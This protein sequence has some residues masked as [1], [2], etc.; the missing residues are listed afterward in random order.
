MANLWNHPSIIA[1]EALRHLEDALVITK[2]CAVDKTS[3]FTTRA[4]GW[5]VGDV[6]SFKTYGD[7]EVKDFTSSISAQDIRSSTRPMQITEHYDISVKVT[8]REEALDLDSFSEEVLRPAAYRMAEKLDVFVGGK[9]MDGAGLY[10][11]ANM[12]DATN[13]GAAT[14]ALARKYAILQQLTL[15]RFCIVDPTVE[16]ALLGQAWFNQSQTR[17]AAG[18]N[19]LQS[20]IMGRVM[21]MDFMA[22]V[23]FPTTNLTAGTSA[24][25]TTGA[26]GTNPIGNKNGSG[27][28]ILTID[29]T[30]TGTIVAGDR[31]AIPGV[32]RPLIV[33]TANADLT[34]ATTIELVD[35]ITEII[36]ADTDFTIIN[37]GDTA[38]VDAAIFDDRSLA[39]ASPM[40]DLPQDRVSAIASNNGINL[41]IVK[42]YDLDSKSTTLSIDMLA[43]AFALD[44]RRITLLGTIT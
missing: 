14:L 26:A 33:K 17:G 8:A 23:N 32:R 12:W 13:G 9:I 28:P 39:F 22:S 3:E 18:V 31:L 38:T 5:K 40:L 24:N 30:A 44:P 2:A 29:G 7:Y 16:A 21:G 6:V 42:G 4:N 34:S 10:L 41:R 15:N 35:P 25:L 37:V 20:G 1:A 27:V 19:T 43:G 36:P 11:N